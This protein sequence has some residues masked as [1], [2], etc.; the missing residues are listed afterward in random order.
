MANKERVIL[1]KEIA[2]A[3][4]KVRRSMR[5]IASDQ[6]EN[7]LMMQIPF[8]AATGDML[9]L[10]EFALKRPDL[11]LQ[12]IA[13]GYTTKEENKLTDEVSDLITVWLDTNFEGD[14]AEDV[15]SFA[16]ELINFFEEKFT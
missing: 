7:I 10:K 3:M 15:R 2:E 12:A 5:E 9:T 16:G 14:E 1:P 8:L 11:Y 6:E 4:G 13:N